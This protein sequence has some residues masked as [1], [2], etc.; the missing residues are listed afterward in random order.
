[1]T[2]LTAEEIRAENEA[3]SKAYL[4]TFRTPWGQKVM[5]DLMKFCNFRIS[6][7]ID[8]RDTEE[9]KRQVFLR[10]Q[11]FLSFTPEELGRLFAG[12]PI[13]TGTN[14]DD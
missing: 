9:G 12:Q 4:L 7:P 5:L 14:P 3:L 2:D 8:D 11:N 1:M 6:L 13:P 10:I